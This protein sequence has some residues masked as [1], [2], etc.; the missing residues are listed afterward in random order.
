MPCHFKE[1][2]EGY[3]IEAMRIS[4]MDE[5]ETISWDRDKA[6]LI[7]IEMDDKTLALPKTFFG[8]PVYRQRPYIPDEVL[9]KMM[10][11]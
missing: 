2:A 11:F 6:F 7:E 8:D 9:K 3:G 4:S 1:I 10:D 5:L